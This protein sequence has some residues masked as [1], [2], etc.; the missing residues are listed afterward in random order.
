MLTNAILIAKIN[1]PTL[2]ELLW[3][4]WLTKQLYILKMKTNSFGRTIQL[5]V[6]VTT[7]QLITSSDNAGWGIANF[8][9]T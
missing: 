3:A 2:V 5:L 1:L 4:K 8:D 9:A 6:K 7:M